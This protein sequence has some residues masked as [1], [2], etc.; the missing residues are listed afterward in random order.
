MSENYKFF[1]NKECEYFPC[2]PIDNVD[3][4]NCIFCYCPLYMLGKDCGGNFKYNDKGVKSCINCS[5]PHLRSNYQEIT[6]SF[7]KITERM[8]DNK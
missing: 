6:S 3:D 5:R 7:H 2:H 8:M 1:Q 4:F